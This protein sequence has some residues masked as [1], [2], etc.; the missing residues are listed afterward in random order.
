MVTIIQDDGAE[1]YETRGGISVSRK[2]RPV[3]YADAI[4][5]SIDKLDERRGA[6]FSSNYEYPGRYTRWDTAIVD[7]PLGISCRGRAV[8]IEAY[9]E[10]GEV[11]LSFIADKLKT[12]ADLTLGERSARRLNLVVNEPSRIFTEEERSKIPT[13]FT[14]L[15]AVTDLFFSEADSAIGLFGAFGYDLAFQFDAIKYSLERPQDQRDMVLYLPDEILVVDHYSAKAWIDRYD[16]EKDGLSTAEKSGEIAP[17]PFQS[18]A[19][20]P[21]HGDHRPGEY[22]ELVTKAKESFRRGDLFEVVP[23]QK[24]ME[25]CDSKPSEISKRLKEINPSPYSFFI[26]LGH[27]EYLVGASPEMFVRVSGRRIETCPI[28]G[29]IRRGEDPIADSEQIL[30]LLNSKKDESELTMCSDVDRNDKSRVCEPGSV[31]VIGRR[32]IEMYSRL[33][34]TVDHIEGRLRDGMDAFDGFLSHAWAVTVTGAPKLWAMRFI[35]AHEKSPRAWY[36]GAI[37]MVG[38]NGDMNTGLTLRTVRIKDGI[39]EVRAGA[40]LLNDSN[41]EEEEAETELKASAMIAAIRDAKSGND[42]KA[43]RGVASVGH[44]VKILLVDHEDSFVHTLANY[45]RQTGA[46]V[47]TVRSPVADAVFDEMDPDLVVLSPG[48]GSPK[49]FDC[50]ATIKKARARQLPIFGV[51]LGL[52]ALAEAYGGE[53]R[54]LAVPMHGKPSRIRVLEPGIVFSGLAKEVTVGRYHSIFADPS[55]LPR[56]F[57]ITAESDD[58]TIMGIEHAKEP[59]AAVQFHPESIMTLGQDA[60]MRMIENVVAHLARRVK[61]KAA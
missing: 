61:V 40:T 32:Q 15:R 44:G 16:F 55:T 22:A 9:N 46:T 56:D 30:K 50:K 13:V 19:T 60:G 41:P 39:A 25:R 24:F 34:H 6:V 18:T 1:I 49:D 5:S 2:R 52:Q 23:G 3:S 28:S 57:I 47:S 21:P 58:G 8:W 10:R 42:G 29:T 4:S 11:L 36:G 26:N 27:Q 51:C 17:E 59:V 35:E 31:K 12:V 45:F 53:L 43:K 7:P 54:H 14:V 37:G 33:I 38:F 20:I 48:P